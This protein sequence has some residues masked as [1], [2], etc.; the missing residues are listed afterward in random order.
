[1]IKKSH[2][3]GQEYKGNI[4][5]YRFGKNLT[6]EDGVRIFHPE[7]IIIGDNVYI[8]HDTIL[9]GYHDSVLFIGD[10]VWIGP[11]CYFHSAGNITIESQVGIGPSVKILTSYHDYNKYPIQLNPLIFKKVMIG[12]GSD[13][14]MGSVILPG[15]NIGKG[16]QIGAGSVVT[17][18]VISH[19]VVTGNP[20]KYIKGVK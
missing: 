19:S 15:V 2:G 20:A 9:Y 18:D 17:K 4:Y 1:M 11:Q 5:S 12:Y 13:I 10:D 7:N 8:G 6:I 3:I 16:S 14:G